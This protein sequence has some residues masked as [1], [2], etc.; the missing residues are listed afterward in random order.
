MAL[1]W[2]VVPSEL[3]RTFSNSGCDI[4]AMGAPP[5]RVLDSLRFGDPSDPHTAY[6]AACSASLPA[7]QAHGRATS[8]RAI[9]YQ[10]GGIHQ[11]GEALR[12][13]CQRRHPT[14]CAAWKAGAGYDR[15]RDALARGSGGFPAAL[16]SVP[17]PP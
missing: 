16:S 11:S 8:M 6:Q 4:V 13:I 14:G 2:V 9:G 5:V 12:C 1:R 7:I 17:T 10:S 3:T 15:N